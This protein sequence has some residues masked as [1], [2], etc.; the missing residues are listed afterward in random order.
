MRSHLALNLATFVLSGIAA[1]AGFAT[2]ETAAPLVIEGITSENGRTVGTEAMR[3][4]GFS[5]FR[6]PDGGSHT[7]DGQT[8]G[9]G[10]V[11]RKV[12]ESLL[13]LRKVRTRVAESRSGFG[14]F[15]TP[16]LGE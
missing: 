12:G 1:T 15:G 6:A 3:D 8:V 11:G 16:D 9:A 4:R 5:V 13:A 2:P 14:L 7:V 10:Q